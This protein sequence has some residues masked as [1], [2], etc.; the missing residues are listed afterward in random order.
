MNGCFKKDEYG[1]LVLDENGNR[2]V[3]TCD[4]CSGSFIYE[5]QTGTPYKT[6]KQYCDQDK[7]GLCEDTSQWNDV[8]IEDAETNNFG[9]PD[10]ENDPVE[11]DRIKNVICGCLTG[12]YPAGSAEAMIKGKCG[13]SAATFKNWFKSNFSW[14]PGRTTSPMGDMPSILSC[15]RVSCAKGRDSEGKMCTQEPSSGEGGGVTPYE[16]ITRCQESWSCY[17]DEE[18]LCPHGTN[19]CCLPK[20]SI[21]GLGGVD[22]E[23]ESE[24]LDRCGDDKVCVHEW[25]IVYDCAAGQWTRE[26]GGFSTPDCMAR[27]RLPTPSTDWD[28]DGTECGRKKFVLVG[29]S[30]CDDSESCTRIANGPGAPLEVGSLPSETPTNC[31][32][33]WCEIDSELKL[34]GNC[35]S[36]TQQD[37][38]VKEQQRQALDFKLE[39]CDSEKCQECPQGYRTAG[40]TGQML[41]SQSL[42]CVPDCNI[43]PNTCEEE[44]GPGYCCVENTI[45]FDGTNLCEP[46]DGCCEPDPLSESQVCGDCPEKIRSLRF[47]D[48]WPE[49]GNRPFG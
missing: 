3:E 41:K 44:F 2:V 8:P 46:C 30:P 12:N 31:C 4:C 11:M 19:F 45:L 39:P 5:P 26:N 7:L 20:Y 42:L 48:Q 33:S 21:D 17:E 14:E 38:T 28:D 40:G 47:Q 32:G 27:D 36:G 43:S 18:T 25:N 15:E 23:A 16:C 13:T 10:W 29:E 34:T 37:W 24:C 35:I 1:N 9:N 6:V 49:Y 22:Y